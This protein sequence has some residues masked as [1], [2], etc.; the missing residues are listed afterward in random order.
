MAPDGSLWPLCGL[1]R[2]KVWK[3]EEAERL[4]CEI[5]DVG[6]EAPREIASGLRDH[7]TLEEMQDSLVLVVCNLRAARLA[8]FNSNG[9]VLAAKGSDGKVRLCSCLSCPP[10]VSCLLRLVYIS[11]RRRGSSQIA[12]HQDQKPSSSSLACWMCVVCFNHLDRIFHRA[13]LSVC[14]SMLVLPI[15]ATIPQKP[16]LLFRAYPRRV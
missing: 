3:H 13:Y 15:G 6:E 12:H 14:L 10:Y 9:M 1:A 8:G 2:E 5:I 11:H 7:L 16:S 4:Y